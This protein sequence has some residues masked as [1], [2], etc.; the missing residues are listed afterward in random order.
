MLDSLWG[1]EETAIFIN[2]TAT[3]TNISIGIISLV[4]LVL[5]YFVL[6][7]SIT[8]RK[9]CSPDCQTLFFTHIFST[10]YVPDTVMFSVYIFV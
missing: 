2:F 7:H 3:H 10:F 6:E 5:K 1:E 4:C 8:S 9:L